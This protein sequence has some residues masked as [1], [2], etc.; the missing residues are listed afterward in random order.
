MDQ[1]ALERLARDGIRSFPPSSLGSTADWAFDFCEASDDARYS[2][3]A[4]ALWAIAQHF[5]TDS[6]ALLAET[7]D[8]LDRALARD[9]PQVLRE[10]KG[11]I[12][13][14]LAR[15]LRERVFEILLA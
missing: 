7:V 13:T 15:A 14:D 2:A 9:L 6:S 11:P 10:H 3:L 5:D 12:A 8:E 1:S 4:R